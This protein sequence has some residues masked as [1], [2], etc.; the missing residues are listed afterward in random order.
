MCVPNGPLFQRRA[1]KSLAPLFSTKSIM[2][3]LIFSGFL[4]E[5]AP[6]F[7]HP[8]IC[9]YVSLRNFSR[10]LILLVLHELT[11]IF[12]L[13]PAKKWVQNIKGQYMTRSTIWMIKYMNGSVFFKC[14]AYGRGYVLK[15]WLA[16]PYQNLSPTPTPPPPPPPPPL[17][18]WRVLKIQ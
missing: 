13:Q 4:Y 3:D 10:L 9:T 8:G 5:K 1:G 14:Q 6:F 11:V 16:Q 12:V 18:V 7:W 17:E 15:Y 2:N